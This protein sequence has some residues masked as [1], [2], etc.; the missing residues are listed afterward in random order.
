[1]ALSGSLKDFEVGDVF[2]LISNQTKTG[3]LVIRRPERSANIYFREGQVVRAEPVDENDLSPLGSL[4]VLAEV[5]TERQL[6]QALEVQKKSLRSIEDILL[7]LDF[8]TES[9]LREFIKLQ[10]TETIYQLFLWRTGEYEF[11]PGEIPSETGWDEKI[12]VENILMEGVRMKDEWPIIRNV[13]TSP[14][15]TFRLLRTIDGRAIEEFENLPPVTSPLEKNDKIVYA[16][17]R[18][19]RTVR[20]LA[21]LS[22]LGEFETSRVLARMASNGFVKPIKPDKSQMLASELG[23]KNIQ[24]IAR[25]VTQLA[26][27]LLLLT[28]IAFVAVVVSDKFFQKPLSS[29]ASLSTDDYLLP[30]GNNQKERLKKALEIYFLTYGKYPPSLNSLVDEG[31]ISEKDLRFPFE[32]EFFY[33]TNSP[34]N[35]TYNLYL[36]LK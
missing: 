22:K 18:D 8:I 32:D 3:T 25:V 26:F 14:Y 1:M 34:S 7:E 35:T 5:I 29:V 23:E 12:D 24:V 30:L 21:A 31:F 28:V 10:T 27:G 2:Q 11:V 16:L 17:I 13:I 15:M 33:T 9:V 19:N 20:K 36:P 4:L 6:E